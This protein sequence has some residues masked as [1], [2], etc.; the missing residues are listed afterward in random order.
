MSKGKGLEAR[1]DLILS[2]VRKTVPPLCLSPLVSRRH[3][4]TQI[5]PVCNL[6]ARKKKET[7]RCVILGKTQTPGAHVPDPGGTNSYRRPKTVTEP[8]RSRPIPRKGVGKENEP[9]DRVRHRRSDSQEY[10][11]DTSQD[12]DLPPGSVE[13]GTG[14]D[15]CPYRHSRRGPDDND[16]YETCLDPSDWCTDDHTCTTRDGRFPGTRRSDHWLLGDDPGP[17]ELSPRVS[18]RET[19]LTGDTL[20]STGLALTAVKIPTPSL[21]GGT[22]VLNCTGHFEPLGVGPNFFKSALQCP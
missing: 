8:R 19:G 12:R 6:G 2:R 22:T 3:T 13:T 4:V 17:S 11:F 1:Q 18:L 21:Q 7:A 10:V 5:I 16:W 15:L 9:L 14:T 20:V